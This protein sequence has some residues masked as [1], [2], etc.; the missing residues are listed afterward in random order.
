[1][2]IRKAVDIPSSEITPEQV[3]LNRRQFMSGA[4][5]LGAGLLLPTA[6][7]GGLQ[8]DDDITPENIVTSYN[9]FYEFG[10]DKSDPAEYAHNL[11][12]APGP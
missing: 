5:G 8:P 3:Y 7:Q 12:T 4:A 1:M 10:T 2:L 9:N 6:A 11:T